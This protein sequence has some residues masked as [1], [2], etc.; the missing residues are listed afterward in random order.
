M[1][2]FFRTKY[3]VKYIIAQFKENFRIN[4][5]RIYWI[6]EKL[7]E[8]H[9]QKTNLSTHAMRNVY[10]YISEN[11]TVRRKWV[12]SIQIYSIRN[13]KKKFRKAIII[14]CACDTAKYG[15]ILPFVPS[16][17][18]ILYFIALIYH[19]IKYTHTH[20]YIYRE[21]ISPNRL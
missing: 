21:G 3:P 14:Q 12:N 2:S 6:S 5:T 16:I 9:E 17:K 4:I 1:F 7:Q 10:C 20:G 18:N 13:V 11:K 15:V 8:T 19:I